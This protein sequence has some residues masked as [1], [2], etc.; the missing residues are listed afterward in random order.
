[1]LQAK[2]YYLLLFI[3]LLSSKS[4]HSQ[5]NLANGLVAYYPFNGN[6]NDV[7]GNGRN[8]TIVNSLTLTQDRFGNP[9]SAYEFNGGSGYIRVTD[10]GAFSNARFS[11]SFW[12]KTNSGALQNLIAKRDFITS[13]GSGGAQYQFA[14]NY[15]PFPG[16]VSNLLGNN[17]TCND[18]SSSSYINTG[19]TLCNEKWYH[20]VVTF[21]GVTHKLFLD[22]ILTRS[23]NTVFSSMLTGCNSEIRFGNWWSLDLIPFSGS[24]DE[25]RWYNRA[26]NQAEI[27]LLFNNYTSTSGFSVATEAGANFSVCSNTPFRLN[28]IASGAT[29]YAWTPRQFLNDSTLQSPTATIT[30]TTK[31]YVTVKNALGC[32]G[33]DSVTVSVLA[34]TQFSI[35]PP[36]SI[37]PGSQTQLEAN[38]GSEYS[39]SPPALVSNPLISNPTTNITNTQLFT[40]K[41]TAPL[42]NVS[43][44]LSTLVSFLPKPN[45][46]VTK[47]NDVDCST[48]EAQLSALGGG[49]SYLWSPASSLD[50]ATSP[51]PI[52]TPI[53]TTTYYVTIKDQNGCIATDSVIV[54]NNKTNKGLY[55]MP[56]AFT[57]NGDGI[58]DCFGVKYWGVIL[59][60]DFSIYNRYG[61]RVFHTTEPTKCWNGLYKTLKPEPGNYVYYIKA[62]TS[63]D[64]IEKKGN[65]LLIR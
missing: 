34:P 62:S 33:K 3:F 37:C 50:D 64:E 52:A 63:C 53:S 14:I 26:L 56:N 30:T 54:Y 4:L 48:T 41:I 40:V 57:P 47:S 1:M 43:S 45:L 39:W 8:G 16:Y 27:D 65:V 59:E 49:V 60:F 23:E 55:N 15:A 61:E 35:N 31:F 7:S 51:T 21:D 20:A 24:M 42:C 13:A 17:V 18:A 36:K 10:N 38:G 2:S 5:V 25:I 22:G 58:N 44:E 28:A 9:N 11:L 19:R 12:Y 46:A 32:L 29:E 6:A